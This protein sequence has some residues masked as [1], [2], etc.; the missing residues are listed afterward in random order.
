MRKNKNAA[1]KGYS[2]KVLMVFAPMPE[3]PGSRPEDSKVLN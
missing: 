1:R 2:N 3:L